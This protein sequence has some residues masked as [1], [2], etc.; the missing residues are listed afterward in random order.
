[1]WGR[2]LPTTETWYRAEYAA[3]WD[4]MLQ[5][6]RRLPT[7]ETSVTL[8]GSGPAASLQWGR[9]LRTTETP[10]RPPRNLHPQDAS[11]G[12]PSSDDGDP[13]RPRPLSRTAAGFNGAAVFRRR[14]PIGGL[15]VVTG[16]YRASMGPPSSD[17]GDHNYVDAIPGTLN[18]LQWGRRLPT[19][20]T[21]RR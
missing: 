4:T 12:P 9:R 17:D 3:L 19:T 20:E 7:T 21:P 14:R 1:Q 5:W 10:P 8:T 13:T 15:P 18:P 16:G 2:R 11:M 6:G